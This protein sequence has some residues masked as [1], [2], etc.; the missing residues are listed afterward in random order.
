[1]E[2]N[3]V[4]YFLKYIAQFIAS[5]SYFDL[6]SYAEETFQPS[7]KLQAGPTIKRLAQSGGD[8]SQNAFVASRKATHRFI[9][10]FYPSFALFVES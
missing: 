6:F 4:L 8:G 9:I 2:T 7:E 5:S 1:M 3:K 10:L